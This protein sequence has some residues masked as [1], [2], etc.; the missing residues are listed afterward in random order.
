MKAPFVVVFLLIC[1]LAVVFALPITDSKHSAALTR[2]GSRLMKGLG[3][4]SIP[5]T[6][7]SMFGGGSKEEKS[8][9]S[10]ASTKS[11]KS[12]NASEKADTE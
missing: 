5:L 3:W 10:T 2:R 1:T 8:S 7:W 6:L 11:G 9:A 12:S 4:A